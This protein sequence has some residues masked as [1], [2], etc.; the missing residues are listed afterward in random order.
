[1]EKGPPGAGKSTFELIDP[2]ILFGELH[3]KEGTSFL[4]LGCGRGEYAIAAA[5]FTGE[6]QIYGIDLWA[7]GIAVLQEQASAKGLRNLTGWVSDI[8]KQVP[9]NN[10]SIDVCLMATVL[11]DLGESDADKTLAEVRRVV[12][13]EGLLAV[14]EFKKI[15]GPPGPPFRIRLSPEDVSR[16]VTPHGFKERRVLEVGPYHYLLTFSAHGVS[17]RSSGG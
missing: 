13:P 7:E 16:I 12:T 14:V 9:L 4:D 6:G 17:Q 1:M 11:H 5:V 8:S 15:E 3:L 10:R 2:E